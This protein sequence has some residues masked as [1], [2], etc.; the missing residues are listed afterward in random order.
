MA[1][2][3]VKQSKLVAACAIALYAISFFTC[4]PISQC[5]NN[6]EYVL[7]YGCMLFIPLGLILPILVASMTSGKSNAIIPFTGVMLTESVMM[8]V[9]AIAT[10]EQLLSC[11]CLTLGC[12]LLT[13]QTYKER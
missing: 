12:L 1:E 2:K 11:S 13:I 6:V 7:V 8:L 5:K 10:N 4:K 9:F 3:N